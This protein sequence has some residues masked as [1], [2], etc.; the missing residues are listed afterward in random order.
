VTDAGSAGLAETGSRWPVK[1]VSAR[2][3]A[4][5]GAL[6]WASVLAVLIAVV[7]TRIAENAV[8][9]STAKLGMESAC[10]PGAV[11]FGLVA[12]GGSGSDGLAATLAAVFLCESVGPPAQTV[13]GTGTSAPVAFNKKLVKGTGLVVTAA[14]AG[15]EAVVGAAKAN[16]TKFA[17]MLP[18]LLCHSSKSRWMAKC[19]CPSA[20]QSDDAETVEIQGRV[21]I[22]R[23]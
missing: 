6:L 2:S 23:S 1:T 4:T 19:L 5:D 14:I 11:R 15:G 7:W 21:G 3:F 9:T 18:A 8:G 22:G 10:V 16:W 12:I 17:G 20:A 13:R